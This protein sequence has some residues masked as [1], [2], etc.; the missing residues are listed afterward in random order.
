[1]AQECRLKRKYPFPHLA[2]LQFLEVI[3]AALLSGSIRK[4]P[5]HHMQ[6]VSIDWSSGHYH[7]PKSK[8][9]ERGKKGGR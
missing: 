6:K 8:K 7:Y 1:M 2:H 3:S 9:K 5:P 4:C